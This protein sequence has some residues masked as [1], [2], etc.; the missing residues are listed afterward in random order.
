M[1]RKD[2]ASRST[3]E[4]ADALAVSCRNAGPQ[5]AVVKKKP[6]THTQS[7]RHSRLGSRGH[8]GPVPRG[9][10]QRRRQ[11]ARKKK[12]IFSAARR[13]S[14]ARSAC[15]THTSVSVTVGAP[16]P[17]PQPHLCSIEPPPNVRRLPVSCISERGGMQRT[18]QR[19]TNRG[20]DLSYLHGIGTHE[21]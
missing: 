21:C 16:A 7:F 8:S 5:T 10:A 15:C 12:K 17:A 3:E 2:P 1:I 20:R 18:S 6:H 19:T 4:S 14:K 13:K 9:R 11:K